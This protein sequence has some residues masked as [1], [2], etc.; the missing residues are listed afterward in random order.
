MW[1]VSRME[2][3]LAV[4]LIIAFCSTSVASRSVIGTIQENTTWFLSNLSVRP[5]MTASLEYHVQYPVVE[6]RSRPIITFYYNG[7]NSPNL[8]THCETDMYGQL[9]NEDL[10]VPLNEDYRHK[11]NCKQDKNKTYYHCWGKTEIQDFEPKSYSFSFCNECGGVGSGNLNGL[12]YNVTI[13]DERNVTSCVDLNM[14]PGQRIDRC[15]R[16][17][18][19]AAI[20]NQIGD[21]DLETAVWELEK[22]LGIMDQVIDLISHKG[23]LQQLYQMVCLVFL[24]ECLPEQNKLV[25]PCREDCTA[26][27]DNCLEKKIIG[28]LFDEYVLNCDYLPSVKGNIS[29]YTSGDVCGPPPEINHGF[30]LGKQIPFAKQGHVVHYACNDSWNLTGSPKSTCQK[31]GEWTT[32]PQ[33]VKHLVNLVMIICLGVGGFIVLILIVSSVVYC[34]MRC[35]NKRN[36]LEPSGISSETNRSSDPLV[37]N[38]TLYE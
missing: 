36:D 23:C 6:G 7:Q 30:I 12:W 37:Y 25:L 28:Y 1:N 33:C 13:Y 18:Q 22:A 10:A 26:L 31:S 32:P 38:E 17:Y 16:S 35:R 8:L 14:T 27:L 5:A 21:T 19:F 9:R 3:S 15:E 24:P 34:C 2:K 11:F 4:S 29:C 20:P